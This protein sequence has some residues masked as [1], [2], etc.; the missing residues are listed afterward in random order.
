MAEGEGFE[1]PLEFPLKRFSRPPVSTAHTTLRGEECPSCHYCTMALPMSPIGEE[2]DDQ[3]GN[4]HLLF[5]EGADEGGDN[6]RVELA[7]G[8]ALEDLAGFVSGAS[9]AIGAVASDGVVGIGHGEDASFER[10]LIAGAIAVS[11]AV[12]AVVVSKD[13]GE[14]AAQ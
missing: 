7:T 4:F 11:G 6:V 9:L 12:E 13:D 1:P 8:S 2:L 14:N 10:N 3:I 5:A